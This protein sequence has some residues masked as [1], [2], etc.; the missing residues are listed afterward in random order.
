[1]CIYLMLFKWILE[2]VKC[3]CVGTHFYTN[4]YVH[5]QSV[6][7]DLFFK[8]ITKQK[9]PQNY[10]LN[11]LNIRD[12]ITESWTRTV[13]SVCSPTVWSIFSFKAGV[14]AAPQTWCF[15]TCATFSGLVEEYTLICS[16][17]GAEVFGRSDNR[18]HF[19]PKKK[20]SPAFESRFFLVSLGQCGF[21]GGITS[22]W[23]FPPCVHFFFFKF[24]QTVSS[25]TS[26]SSYSRQLQV[27]MRLSISRSQWKHLIWWLIIILH[28]TY[29]ATYCTS[30]FR[31]LTLIYLIGVFS[32]FF[33]I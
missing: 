16:L 20:A 33:I 13:A 4:A 21:W 14:L 25:V 1:M 6:K 19:R 12:R 17:V 32:L 18:S 24:S 27:I 29:A 10:H 30:S 11:H 2:S 26:V 9:T 23:K 5:R 22:S 15:Y 3:K 8:S 7:I 28:Q 31:V